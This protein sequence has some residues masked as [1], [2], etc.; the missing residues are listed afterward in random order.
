MTSL[1]LSDADA[2]EIAAHGLTADEVRRQLRL[3]AAPPP[4][5]RLDRPCTIGDGIRRMSDADVAGVIPAYEGACA[6]GRITKAV[7]PGRPYRA[8]LRDLVAMPHFFA[9]AA[10]SREGPDS[11]VSTL[12]GGDN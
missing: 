6:A 11:A 4:S 12:R 8:A 10:H 2:S 9:R 3:F 1:A 7:A 5:L